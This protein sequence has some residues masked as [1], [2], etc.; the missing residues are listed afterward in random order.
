MFLCLLNFVCVSVWCLSRRRL[1]S[2]RVFWSDVLFRSKSSV[3]FKSTNLCLPFSRIQKKREIN[4][5]LIGKFE[6]KSIPLIKISE[7]SNFCWM[8]L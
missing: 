7:V 3:S 5:V 4:N 1:S 6:V 2:T 8:E